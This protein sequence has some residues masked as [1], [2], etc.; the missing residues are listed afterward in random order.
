[1]WE[2]ECGASPAIVEGLPRTAVRIKVWVAGYPLLHRILTVAAAGQI[3]DVELPRGSQLRF[4]SPPDL[5]GWTSMELVRIE[6]G[7]AIPVLLDP[8]TGW[9]RSVS[10]APPGRYR[11]RMFRP[12]ESGRLRSGNGP[13]RIRVLREVEF[14]VEAGVDREFEWGEP[15]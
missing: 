4:Q 11:A 14:D 9:N 12:V 5:E 2:R 1:M 8:K 15:K 6:D 7:L 13:G 3:I 10:P